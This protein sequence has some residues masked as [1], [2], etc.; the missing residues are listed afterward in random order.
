ME[1]CLHYTKG[2]FWIWQRVGVTLNFLVLQYVE[3]S[4]VGT[5]CS[6]TMCAAVCFGKRI[7]LREKVGCFEWGDCPK[8][9]FG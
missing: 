7:I 1:H 3:R 9:K 8:E 5:C 4:Q 2:T 6:S